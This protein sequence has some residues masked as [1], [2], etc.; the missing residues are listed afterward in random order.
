M[1]Q[2]QNRCI[3]FSPGQSSIQV[4]G[5]RTALGSGTKLHSAPGPHCIDLSLGPDYTWSPNQVSPLG[6]GTKLHL[7]MQFGPR[8]KCNSVFDLNATWSWSGMG[9]LVHVQNADWSQ[10]IWLQTQ[11]RFGSKPKCNSVPEPI[12]Q[13]GPRPKCDLVLDLNAV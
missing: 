1:V 2:N 13:F 11:L 8:P 10:T 4:K 7:R 9:Y 6:S 5:G 12:M 3:W